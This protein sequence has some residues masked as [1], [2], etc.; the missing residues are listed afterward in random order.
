MSN[1]VIQAEGISK[2]YRIGLEEEMHDSLVSAVLD[3]VRR[4]I[5]NFRRLRR[6]AAFGE[7]AGESRDAIWALKEVSFQ[8]RKGEVVGVIGQNGAGKSTLLKILSGIT[9]PTRGRAIVSGRIGSLLEVG[10]GF[11]PELTG[12]ENVY[13]NGTILGMKK[14]EVDGK[15]D[16]IVDFSGIKKFVDTPIKRYSSGMKVRLAF[17]VAA[18]LNPEILLVDEVLAVGD[19]SFQKKCLGKME[20]IRKEG[21]TVLFVS[22]NMTA[23]QRLCGR[24]ILFKDGVVICDGDVREAVECYLCDDSVEQYGTSQPNVNERLR[25]NGLGEQARLT[26]CRLFDAVENEN[27]SLPFGQ[28]FT[29]EL[30]CIGLSDVG[31]VAFVVGI[32][33]LTGVRI[34]T[35]VSDE[36]GNT[37]SV[38][39]GQTVRACLRFEDLMLKPGRY[40]LT[41]GLLGL[42]GGMD[43]LDNVR[44]FEITPLLHDA[45]RA[46]N[47][48]WGLIDVAP[49]WNI[50]TVGKS[51]S[52]RQR[53]F[54]R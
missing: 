54:D 22:H 40:S 2:I 8:V 4:P 24:A 42:M 3:F 48:K 43:H 34:T 26:G 17:A 33:S 25:L 35:A 51:E 53:R 41:V 20:D 21:R 44:S 30:D 15:F 5:S 49:K 19:A 27:Y 10:T 31:S 39:K 23:I 11:H 16:E 29:V 7:N 9:E 50:H 37:V 47:D 38:K 1:V 18:H 28:A 52:N 32:D 36:G 6:L 13:L 46:P 14:R 12:R 45:T